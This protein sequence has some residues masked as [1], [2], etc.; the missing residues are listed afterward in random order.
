MYLDKSPPDE[1]DHL[2]MQIAETLGK[3]KGEQDHLISFPRMV[4][5]VCHHNFTT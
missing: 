3:G 5:V 1:D 2:D 4:D